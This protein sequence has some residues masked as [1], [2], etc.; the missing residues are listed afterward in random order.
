M[1]KQFLIKELSNIN[2]AR[3]Q[4][5]RVANLVLA[6]KNRF[7]P[8]L[9]IVFEI[10]NPVSVKAAWVLEFV[11]HKRMDW[12]LTEIDYFTLNISKINN[13][14]A[15][16][17]IAKVCELFAYYLDKNPYKK[18]DYAKNIDQIIETGFDWMLSEHKIAIK[19][20][21]MQTLFLFGKDQKWIYPELKII[22]TG[23]LHKESTGYRNRALKILGRIE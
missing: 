4:R 3:K 14:S 12:L 13:G 1:D 9:E 20:Y 7:K 23:N 2:A 18:E 5:L 19:V 17:P 10:N 16:R 6:S 21:T 22:L 11:A 8:L 15:I